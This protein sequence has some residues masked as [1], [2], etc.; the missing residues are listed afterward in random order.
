[1][2]SPRLGFII[3][4][5]VLVFAGAY[6]IANTFKR[7]GGQT[8]S[9][10]NISLKNVLTEELKQLNENSLEKNPTQLKNPGTSNSNPQDTTNLTKLVASSI[11]GRMKGLD[12]EQEKFFENF[13]PDD[14]EIQK[15]I[16]EAISQI[17]DLN[18]IGGQSTINNN[19]LKISPDNSLTAKAS[20]LEATAKII[21]DNSN[22][23][24]NNPV[25]ALQKL[26]L[27]AET[28][29]VNKIA[30]T[31]SEIYKGFLNAPIPSDWLIL[32][33][34]YLTLLK[35]IESI[36]RGIA[37]FRNDPIKASL[38]G[39]MLPEI[40]NEEAKIREEYYKKELGIKS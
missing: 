29:G 27:D 22:E 28:S 11:F 21:S 38:L 32:H 35:K 16:Q 25:N 2:K 17:Q 20:Y 40:L 24:Y 37:D 12:Q 39:E 9:A 15:T 34:R 36:Y 30:D 7:P 14:P 19:D 18:L 31:Y 1:M 4:T 3:L 13:N 23:F 33:Q 10:I 6:F 5:L 8:T 26:T